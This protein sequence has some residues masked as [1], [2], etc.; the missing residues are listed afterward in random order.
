MSDGNLNEVS[1]TLGKLMNATSEAE[2]TRELI[3]RK[4]D[5]I[6]NCLQKVSTNLSAVTENHA[7]LKQQVETKIMPA[8]DEI[9]S[10]KQKGM[11]V[12]VGIG[13]LAGGSGAIVTKIANAYASIVG[14][15]P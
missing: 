14:K 1:L 6:G 12:L 11:G 15:T 7:E 5:D 4:L 3:F 2:R 13:L 9:K 8:V 10:I